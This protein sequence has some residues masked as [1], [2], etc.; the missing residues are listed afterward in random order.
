[1]VIG[2]T[3]QSG[4]G[5]TTVSKTFAQNGFEVIN[6]D[7][8]SRKVNEHGSLCNRK[9]A[10]FF[11]NCF[12]KAFK[13]DRKKLAEIV[14]SDEKKLKILNNLVFPFITDMIRYEISVCETK[15]KYI[16]L[17]APT[18]FEAGADKLC[19]KIVSVIAD[20]DIRFTR[21]KKRDNID[22]KLIEKRFS[23]QHTSEYFVKMSDF[24]IENNKSVYDAISQTEDVIKRIKDCFNG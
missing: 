21:I 7:L 12:D 10:E 20:K 5:K 1:M 16:L 22:D 17:D 9:L 14:F 18:L 13:L 19:D 2:L 3:G 8:I 15:S 6:C 11:P 4:A 24:I 23:S